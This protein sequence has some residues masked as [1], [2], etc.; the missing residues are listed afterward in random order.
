MNGIRGGVDFVRDNN[1]IVLQKPDVKLIRAVVY[2]S[3]YEMN[4]VAEE[5][6]LQLLRTTPPS[7]DTTYVSKLQ[8]IKTFVTG[9]G[10]CVV[11]WYYYAIT[12]PALSR[13]V[14]QS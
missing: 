9:K 12:T 10:K 13:G 6:L 8:L 5:I 11:P 3:I 4:I 2:K 14:Y 1:N 7:F